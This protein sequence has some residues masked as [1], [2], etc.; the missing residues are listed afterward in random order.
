MRTNSAAKF[1][2]YAGTE[3]GNGRKVK[4]TRVRTGVRGDSSTAGCSALEGSGARLAQGANTE[5]GAA[6]L[7]G[8]ES[9]CWTR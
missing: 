2:D 7:M 4:G 3:A 9:P 6:A 8:H 5:I 1:P